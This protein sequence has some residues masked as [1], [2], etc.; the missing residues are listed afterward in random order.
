MR[1]LCTLPVDSLQG[2]TPQTHLDLKCA[3]LG[4]CLIILRG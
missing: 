3:L 2:E 1:K 4:S